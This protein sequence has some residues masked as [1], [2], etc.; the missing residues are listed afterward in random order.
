MGVAEIKRV[1]NAVVLVL[2]RSEKICAAVQLF[3]TSSNSDFVLKM[4]LDNIHFDIN[5][6]K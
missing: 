4:I 6:G 1:R 2:I 5:S 3:Y